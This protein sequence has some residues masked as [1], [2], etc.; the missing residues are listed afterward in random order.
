MRVQHFLPVTRTQNVNIIQNR[1]LPNG[2]LTFRR[3]ERGTG[4]MR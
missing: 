1:T 4:E 2:E 3:G